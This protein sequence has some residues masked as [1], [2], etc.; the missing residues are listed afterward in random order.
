M[1]KAAHGYWFCA[2]SCSWLFLLF[3]AAKK[4]QLFTLKRTI[5][6]LAIKKGDESTRQVVF[7]NCACPL[8]IA[9]YIREPVTALY[10]A[11]MALNIFT[12]MNLVIALC[13][14]R[15]ILIFSDTPKFLKPPRMF[16]H[17]FE[18][19]CAI[20]KRCMYIIKFV[21]LGVHDRD[22]QKT[23]K[24]LAWKNILKFE[25]GMGGNV[26]YEMSLLRHFCQNLIFMYK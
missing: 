4:P 19:R 16:C 10:T 21:R 12:E 25:L 26:R 17:H 11:E 7:D 18:R 8:H 1:E 5:G 3:G 15:N 20:I 9:L 6:A 13:N 2:D 24:K 23:C 22:L 14:H